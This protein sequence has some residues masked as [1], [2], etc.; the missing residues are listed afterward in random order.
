MSKRRAWLTPDNEPS[1]APFVAFKVWIP[2]L[3]EYE[4]ALRGALLLL[5][6]SDNWERYGDEKPEDV[7]A[8]W[9]EANA[10][11]FAMEK[12]GMTPIGA[13]FAWTDTT[14]PP[15]TLECAGQSVTYIDFPELFGV[16]GYTF[17]GSGLNFNVP[18]LGTHI[19]T[20]T[21]SGADGINEQFTVAFPGVIPVRRLVWVIVS[22]SG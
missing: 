12:A 7:A 1:S 17:G 14:L 6:D 18:N 2:N 9:A 4:A 3:L 22:E 10:R 20:G 19:I 11:T 8:L 5:Q 13:V 21:R 16:I 15:H